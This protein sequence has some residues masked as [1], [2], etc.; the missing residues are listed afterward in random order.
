VFSHGGEKGVKSSHPGEKSIR[1]KIAQSSKFV[2]N[3]PRY[4]MILSAYDE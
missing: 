2:D 4:G 3:L 1:P